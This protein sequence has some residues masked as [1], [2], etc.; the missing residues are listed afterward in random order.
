MLTKKSNIA[1]FA[2]FI[3]IIIG[4]ILLTIINSSHPFLSYYIFKWE[5]IFIIPI[6]GYGVLYLCPKADIPEIYSDS[7]SNKKRLLIPFLS[8]VIFTLLLIASSLILK[9][10]NFNIPFPTSIPAYVVFGLQYEMLYHYIPLTIL[11]WLSSWVITKEKHKTLIFW[12]FASILSLYEPYTQIGGLTAMG[13]IP[14]L[15]WQIIFSIIIF[16][17]N[18]IPIY[19]FKK[20]GLLSLLLFRMGL[21]LVWHI[22][23]PIFY[24]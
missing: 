15:L 21:Y 16:L 7:I 8:G 4:K 1:Y 22:L 2:I 23:W 11:L 18:I 14:N 9:F 13:V 20:N 6:L 12:I 5:Y 19:F 10:P 24:Y 3:T 17:G